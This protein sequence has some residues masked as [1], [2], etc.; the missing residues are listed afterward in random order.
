MEGS[1]QPYDTR[2]QFSAHAHTFSA[3][4]NSIPYHPF[5]STSFR[6][7][8]FG[9]HIYQQPHHPSSFTIPFNH[10]VIN[11]P[12]YASTQP[13]ATDIP[14]VGM[15]PGLSS[16]PS[17]PS[18]Q[19]A[20]VN[21]RGR[22]RKGDKLSRGTKRQAKEN[23]PPIGAGTPPAFGVGPSQPQHLPSVSAVQPAPL[24]H[25]AS[26]IPPH[27][28]A[29]D[30]H[31]PVSDQDASDVWWFIASVE[32]REKP[33]VMPSFGPRERQ[34]PKNSNFWVCRECALYVHLVHLFRS[35]LTL[36]IVRANGK[37]GERITASQ[38][39]FATI[40]KSIIAQ[41][42]IMLFSSTNSRIG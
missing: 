34:K 1:D 19:G 40:S 4:P 25:S 41:H 31:S 23:I 12:P 13:L 35:I 3:V 5:Q 26:Q 10:D 24:R 28:G 18:P 16:M 29:G 36:F 37:H 32:A 38:P 22:K 2:P 21:I 15:Q 9:S 39:R 7:P 11:V 17:D 27:Q 6:P 42:G 30:T 33:S 8:S 14:N 20:A